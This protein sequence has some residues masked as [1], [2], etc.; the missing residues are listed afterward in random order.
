MNY[1]TISITITRKQNDYFT[2]IELT[3]LKL[4]G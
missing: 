1:I 3:L 4:K 2:L